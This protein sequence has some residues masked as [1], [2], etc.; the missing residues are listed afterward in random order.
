MTLW[1]LTVL[2]LAAVLLLSSVRPAAAEIYDVPILVETEDDLRDLLENGDIDEDTFERLLRMLERPVDLNR[3]RRERLFD[4]PGLTYPMVDAIVRHRE[5]VGVFRAVADLAEA[6]IPA[7]VIDQ[8]RPF[9]KVAKRL[10]RPPIVTGNVRLRGIEA[11]E[12]GQTPAFYLRARATFIDRIH[13]GVSGLVQDRIGPFHHHSGSGL[14]WLSAEPRSP[15]FQLPKFYVWADEDRWAAILGSYQIGFAERLTFDETTRSQ[16]DGFYPDDLLS[17]Y[18]ESGRFSVRERLYGAAG[19]IR[20]VPVGVGTMEF[21]AFVSWWP[22]DISQDDVDSQLRETDDSA[23]YGSGDPNPLV[24]EI[25]ADPE[26]CATDGEGRITRDTLRAA[27][28]ETLFG[29]RVAYRPTPDWRV[30]TTAYYSLLDFGWSTDDLHFA[31]SARFPDRDDAGAV[32][33]DLAGHI[34]FFSIFGEY[35]HSFAGGDAVLLRTVLGWQRLDVELLGRYY[36]ERFDNPHA[37][38]TAAPDELDGQRDRD[39]AG[40]RMR[41]N[42]RPFD[43]LRARVEVDFWHRMSLDV[44]NMALRSRFDVDPLDWLTIAAGVD[45]TDKDLTEGG[46]DEEYD[47]DVSQEESETVREV[48]AGVRVAAW[49]AIIA[50]VIPELRIIAFY[51]SVWRDAEVSERAYVYPEDIRLRLNSYYDG[52][53][54]RDHYVYLL[55]AGEII[56]GL[57]LSGRV[58]Y[59]DEEAD[60]TYRGE[61][62][63]EGW[64]QLRWRIV[65]AVYAQL[66]YRVRGFLDDRDTIRA[67]WG[68]EVNPEHL[69][70]GT[71]EVRY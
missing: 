69:L 46:R 58:K 6:G 17:E 54:A 43:I 64:V 70:K 27:Y 57:V 8:L 61:S 34:D 26:F 25:G 56:D 39:E 35:A 51:K 9:A 71:V 7:D 20:D 44:T 19:T 60:F 50:D 10:R 41:L 37:R 62:Y 30:G 53:F 65:D 47:D 22:Y 63:L 15:R 38:G 59:L 5:E 24:C 3:A 67:D 48:G 13:V 36:A 68:P 29:G 21:T 23:F 49:A 4:L 55:V 16:P 31:R 40:G 11:F 45:Y 32:G 42:V 28:T 12:D 14:T 2:G 33:V 1:R 52:N 18:E 66:R